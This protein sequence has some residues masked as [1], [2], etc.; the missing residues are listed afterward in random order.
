MH[1]PTAPNGG[2]RKLPEPKPPGLCIRLILLML[3]PV[4]SSCLAT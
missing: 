1:Q 2:N 4:T 3:H